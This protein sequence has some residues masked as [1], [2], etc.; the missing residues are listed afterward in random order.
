M[1]NIF[2]VFVIGIFVLVSCQ[3]QPISFPNYKYSTVYFAYQ[4]PVRTLIL[5]TDN[6]YDNS[7]DT[8]HQCEIYATMG[9]VYSNSTDRI[10]DVV[11]DNTLCNHLTFDDANGNPV[12]PMPSSYYKFLSNNMQ[13]VIPKGSIMGGI[14]VQLTDAFFADSLSI[15]NTYVIPL[16]ITKVANADSILS[17]E[18]LEGVTNPNPFVAGDWQTLP[19]NYVLYCIKYRNPWDASYLRRGIEQGSD[20]TVVYHE[21]YVEY[22]QVV[23][24]GTNVATVSMHKLLISLNAIKKG[25]VDV[26]FQLLLTFDNNNNCTITN[27]ANASYTVTGTGQYVKNGDEWGNEKRDVLHLKYSVT[28]G[29]L[30]HTMTDTLVMRDRNES[31][32][33]FVPY[34]NQ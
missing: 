25:N 8:A 23:S 21:P 2:F 29:A 20:T 28:F 34:Y 13:I 18:A 9:G 15:Q 7:L 3:N 5:G 24:E 11:V 22:D 31:A 19:K 14:K 32:E 12:L 27:P 10:L 1:K 33:T 4:S 16:R 17:G 6:Q 30:T 26:P